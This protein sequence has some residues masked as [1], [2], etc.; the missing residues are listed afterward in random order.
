MSDI[1]TRL[2]LNAAF[3]CRKRAVGRCDPAIVSGWRGSIAGCGWWRRSRSRHGRN[4]SAGQLHVNRAKREKR[5]VWAGSSTELC[6]HEADT[7][8]A[9]QTRLNSY[10]V[11]PMS[12]FHSS[13][14]LAMKLVIRS[15]HLC[16][17]RLTT[18]TPCER[19]RSSAPMNVRFSPMTTRGIP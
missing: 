12:S 8:K 5:P 16:A 9:H 4:A 14:L 17:L 10:V 11:S 18:S 1:S 19:R 3:P 2:L 7:L 13:G 15:T 6:W